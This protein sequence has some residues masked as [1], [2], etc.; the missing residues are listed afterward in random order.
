MVKEDREIEGFIEGS[1]ATRVLYLV[2][3]SVGIFLLTLTYP[4]IFFNE[5]KY[6][7]LCKI[8]EII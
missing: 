3:I 6:M 5:N 2:F 8:D 1:N 4:V 7:N